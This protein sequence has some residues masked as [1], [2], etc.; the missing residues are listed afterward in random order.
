[1]GSEDA[2]DIWRVGDL[3]DKLKKQTCCWPS[4]TNLW[5]EDYQVSTPVEEFLATF[6]TG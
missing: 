1:M 5:A 2:G 6:K 3:T 4:K